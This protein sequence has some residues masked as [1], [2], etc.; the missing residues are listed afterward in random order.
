MRITKRQLKRII[1]EAIGGWKGDASTGG[2]ESWKGPGDALPG[3]P[4]YSMKFGMDVHDSIIGILS[5][6]FMGGI[7]LAARVRDELAELAPNLTRNEVFDVMDE[8]LEDHTLIFD[9]EEDEWSLV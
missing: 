1:K 8:M 3:D 2:F 6:T 9:E 4:H 5:G 7:E